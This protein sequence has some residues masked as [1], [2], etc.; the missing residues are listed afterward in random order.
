MAAKVVEE[1]EVLEARVREA[2]GDAAK[3]L[4]TLQQVRG[5]GVEDARTAEQAPARSG[6]LG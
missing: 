4:Q 6:L 3:A 2:R 1:R 5:C